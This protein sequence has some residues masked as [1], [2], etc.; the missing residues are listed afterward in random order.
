MSEPSLYIG[1]HWIQGEGIPFEKINPSNGK[2]IATVSSVTA[3]QVA[4]AVAAAREAFAAWE[5]LSLEN[6]IEIL[7]LFAN[8]L[9]SESEAVSQVISLETGKPAWEAAAEAQTMAA[10]IPLS[11]DA[12]QKRCGQ[13]SAGAAVT[14]FR[15]HGVTAVL[16]PFNFPGHLPNGHIV[17]ALLAGNTVVFKASELAPLTARLAVEL[18]E[19]CGLPVGVLNLIQG[20]PD[21]GK[22]LAD[23]PGIDGLFFTGSSQTGQALREQFASRPGK[24]LALEMGGNNPLVVKEVENREAA[25][26]L[27]IQSAYLTSGQRCTCARRLIVPNS[28]WGERFIEDLAEA[29][30]QIVVGAP[31]DTDPVP[32]MGPVI[33]ESAA[34]RILDAQDALLSDHGQAFRKVRLPNPGTALLCPGL[35]DVTEVPNRGDEEIFGPLLQVIRVPNF[36]DAIEEANN[37][38]FGLAAG[39]ISDSSAD[40]ERFRR[41]VRAGIMNWNH[42]L[43]GASG[44]APFGGIGR[45]GNFRPSAFFAADYCSWPSVS[46]EESQPRLPDAP[47]PGI[48]VP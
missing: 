32:F 8:K 38:E 25:I 40:W 13:F 29:I 27:T 31:S 7:Q 9:Q 44:A 45:S 43:T 36:G 17:P 39:L 3:D 20:G 2:S 16:G 26:F 48:S 22:A 5:A 15:P 1:G 28:R 41:E 42:P 12:F 21:A 10:K 19:K 14:R 33:S 23:H 47:P 18:W 46:R 34:G 4:D 24:I 30:D 6:R 35:I 11:I 37:T